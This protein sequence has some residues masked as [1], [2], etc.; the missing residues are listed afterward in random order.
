ML[1][2]AITALLVQRRQTQEE[3]QNLRL[4]RPDPG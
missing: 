3:R 4:I 1:N 2:D